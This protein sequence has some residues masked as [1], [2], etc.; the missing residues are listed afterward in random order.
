MCSHIPTQNRTQN[1]AIQ[2]LCRSPFDETAQNKFTELKLASTCEA[3]TTIRG[4]AATGEKS[5]RDLD[6]LNN[7]GESD[8]DLNVNSLLQEENEKSDCDLD[9]LNYLGGSDR[10]LNVDSL[11]QEENEK[12]DCDLDLLKYL[13]GSDQDLNTDSLLQEENSTLQCEREVEGVES[14]QVREYTLRQWIA[15]S[16]PEIDFN[17]EETSTPDVFVNPSS[18][19]TV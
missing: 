9:L 13:G 16:K 11:L 3:F 5:E 1:D 14:Q 8:Q 6:L 19:R 18:P 7:L 12:S 15:C 2:E 10:D 17:P 4:G